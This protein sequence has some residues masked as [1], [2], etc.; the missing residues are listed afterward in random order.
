MRFVLTNGVSMEN[1]QTDNERMLLALFLH[2]SCFCRKCGANEM[3][4]VLRV[5]GGG[6]MKCISYLHSGSF[7]L[8]GSDS[9]GDSPFQVP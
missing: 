3:T 7:A 5:A 4:K 2:V 6:V 9:I 1:G 8:R